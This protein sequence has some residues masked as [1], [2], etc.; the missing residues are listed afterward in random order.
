MGKN[1]TKSVK[2]ELFETYLH[3][4]TVCAGISLFSTLQIY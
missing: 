1:L 4:L 2:F 3:A